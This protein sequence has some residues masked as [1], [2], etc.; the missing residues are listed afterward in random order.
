MIHPLDTPLTPPPLHDTPISTTHTPPH[1][2]AGW[3]ARAWLSEWA[4]PAV[5]ARV[6]KLVS[7]GSP[8]NPPPSG[9]TTPPPPLC[10]VYQAHPFMLCL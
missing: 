6:R 3:I 4:T 1:T 2:T 10:C 8:H 5:K 7:L 9:I